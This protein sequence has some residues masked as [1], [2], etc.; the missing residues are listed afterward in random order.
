MRLGEVILEATPPGS[1]YG[2]RPIPGVGPMPVGDPVQSREWRQR[3][4]KP[5]REYIQK[6]CQP[7]LQESQGQLV[8]RGTNHATDQLA[9]VRT[10][11]N[12]RQPRDS[13]PELHRLLNHW[14][15]SVEGG[16]TRSNSVFLT[17]SVDVSE[18]YGRSYVV[19]PVGDFLY[20]W[21]P[22]MEDWH[23]ETEGNLDTLPVRNWLDRQAVQQALID[24]DVPSL[25]REDRA[26][27]LNDHD[28]SDQEW[29]HA[30][31]RSFY[32]GEY[33]ELENPRFWN[34]DRL[35]V[36]IKVDQDLVPAIMSGNEI[37]VACREYVMVELDYWLGEVQA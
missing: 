6:H 2:A 26:Q 5:L 23:G 36:A 29:L 25:R 14:I 7:W 24:L 1:K 4:K 22:E 35:R 13:S 28:S 8:Y 17:G 20:T 12:S 16:A 37:M 3:S 18:E 19:F 10:T 33:L 31:S 30:A 11:R 21:S 32:M 34:K 9:F 27:L 15:L